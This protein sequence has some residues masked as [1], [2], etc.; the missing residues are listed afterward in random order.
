MI[1][2]GTHGLR[3]FLQL[4]PRLP[5]V[6]ALPEL[7]FGLFQG[8]HPIAA[9]HRTGDGERPEPAQAIRTTSG[10][11]DPAD[12]P[13]AAVNGVVRSV[14]IDPGTKT[15]RAKREGH[16]FMLARSELGCVIR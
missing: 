2:S 12:R 5:G 16:L 6:P 11:I 1:D 8:R 7:R 14:L 9:C 13:S 4:R 15:G 3:H 10:L